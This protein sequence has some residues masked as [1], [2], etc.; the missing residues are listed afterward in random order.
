[1]LMV[2]FKFI[3]DINSDID[4]KLLDVELQSYKN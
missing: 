1:M 2:L 4:Y 3:V